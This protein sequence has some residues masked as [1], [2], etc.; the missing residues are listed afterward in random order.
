MK[1]NIETAAKRLLEAQDV[2]VLAHRRPDGDT[3]GTAFALYYALKQIGKRV[4]VECADPLPNKFT[5]LYKDYTE[6][7]FQP[8]FIVAVDVAS[9]RL[10]GELCPV[11]GDKVDLAVDHHKSNEG[12]AKETLLDV[13]APATTELMYFLL[14]AMDINIDRNIANAL[15]TG[16]VTDTGG[17]R[18][19]SVTSRTHLVAS[20]LIDRGAEHANINEVVFESVSRGRIAV[21]ALAIN[22]LEYYLDGR[23][24]LLYLPEDVK[25]EFGISEEELDGISSL[26]RS[27][28]GVDMGVT[29]RGLRDNAYRVSLRSRNNY[30]S[31]GVCERF[32]G[33][34]HANAAGCTI[35][36]ELEDV[37]RQL[38][39]AVEE[40]FGLINK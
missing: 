9:N 6:E 4:R 21:E 31:S 30:D 15:F 39:Q 25:D 34:G 20:K 7:D 26:P 28:D 17:F 36:G 13:E 33:G 10:L 40:E 14:K 11:Y 2:L 3:V 32:G 19:A 37:K 18:F 38:V 1:I 24:A 29:L 8:K 5:Y 16:L 12:Y 23:C 27:V 35:I 22:S